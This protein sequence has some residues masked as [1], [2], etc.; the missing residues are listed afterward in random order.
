MN[1]NENSLY[2]QRFVLEDK[3]FVQLCGDCVVF[4]PGLEHQ[5]HVSWNFVLLQLLHGP[6]PYRNRGEGWTFINLGFVLMV[7]VTISR[8]YDHILLETALV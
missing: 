7:M 6:L 4:G 1:K 3:G 8:G 2:D 5:T